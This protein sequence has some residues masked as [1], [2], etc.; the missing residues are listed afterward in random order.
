MTDLLRLSK[1]F[2]SIPVTANL[3][4]VL[5]NKI[6]SR[7]STRRPKNSQNWPKNHVWTMFTRFQ[8]PQQ[9]CTPIHPSTNQTSTRWTCPATTHILRDTRTVNSMYRHHDCWRTSIKSLWT[10]SLELFYLQ[11]KRKYRRYFWE[12]FKNSFILYFLFRRRLKRAIQVSLH[13]RCYTKLSLAQ[14]QV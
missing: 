8:L 11:F 3:T 12:T 4:A 6:T 2:I 14:L 5:A 7:L 10:V 1:C 9:S 13:S